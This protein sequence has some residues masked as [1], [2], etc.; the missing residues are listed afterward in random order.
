MLPNAGKIVVGG[1][2]IVGLCFCKH[3]LGNLFSRGLNFGISRN[4]TQHFPE[5]VNHLTFF[6]SIRGMP[7][8][9]GNY[10]IL[11]DKPSNIKENLICIVL[12]INRK[13]CLLTYYYPAFSQGIK[14]LLNF[15]TLL[16]KLTK[17]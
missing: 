8:E 16:Q 5:Q 9:R 10:M 2:I 14:D 3:V 17:V 6:K 7:F 4:Q 1:S 11:K 12:L 15:A 13:N